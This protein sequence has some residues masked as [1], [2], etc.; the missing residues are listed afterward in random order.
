[1]GDGGK[2]HILK[3]YSW[4]KFTKRW[5]ELMK[6]VYEKNGSWETRKNYTRWSVK[7]L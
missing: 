3:N 6:E 2:E 1:M 4:E 7:E 5:P